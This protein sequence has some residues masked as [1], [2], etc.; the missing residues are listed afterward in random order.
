MGDLYETLG[1]DK[2]ADAAT[3]KRA[4]RKKAMETHPDKHPELDPKIFQ[5]VELAHRIL[6]DPDKRARYDSTG[7]TE[8]QPD[9]RQARAM[10]MIAQ[11][12][13]GLL[14]R[15]DA[16]HL[17]L[18][19]E[20]RKTLTVAKSEQQGQ[21]KQLERQIEKVEKIRKRFSA[22]KGPDRIGIMLDQKID[23]FKQALAMFGDNVVI[24]DMAQTFIAD[25]VFAPE[26]RSQAPDYQQYNMSNLYAGLTG[27][28]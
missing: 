16:I 5:S 27:T 23:G 25:Q 22:K 12:I 8:D 17:D 9:Q 11:I 3:I 21:T 20:A 19:A 15:P 18:V 26:P 28:R 14:Q 2:T 7:K 10:E 4:Y 6:S 13:E 24:I 1:V